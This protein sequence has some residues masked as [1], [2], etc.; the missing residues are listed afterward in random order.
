MQN[1]NNDGTG[2]GPT[3]VRIAYRSL[4]KQVPDNGPEGRYVYYWPF[5]EAPVPGQWV[6][7]PSS[8]HP[9]NYA[10]VTGLGNV[11]DAN[12]AP[13]KTIASLVPDE[14]VA[15]AQRNA[16]ADM[17]AWLWVA[18]RVAGFPAPGY[19]LPPDE[20]PYSPIPPATGTAPSAH[21]AN[22]YGF[23]W[24]RVHGRAEEYGLPGEQV[25]R[26]KS[27]SER[28]F[29]LSRS[30]PSE[31]DQTSGSSN[32]T[33]GTDTTDTTDSTFSWTWLLAL[34]AVVI[35]VA[36]I[37]ALIRSIGLDIEP[38]PGDWWPTSSRPT[39][40]QP[41]SSCYRNVNGECVPQPSASDS[42]HDGATAECRDGTYSFSSN[43]S[44]SCAGHGGV[45][46]WLEDQP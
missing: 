22:E 16:D 27:I 46:A 41:S 14:V 12:G 30:W 31:T 8:L 24:R 11:E 9:E 6:I 7:V 19:P 10:V 44:G 35:A 32:A 40:S 25:K 1:E 28:W 43:R 37:T 21:V 17:M 39:S 34:A 29:M 20:Y 45:A 23:V 18:Q 26:F 33:S 15:E 3:I 36:V 5:R 2:T 38:D 4:A 42:V 13:L